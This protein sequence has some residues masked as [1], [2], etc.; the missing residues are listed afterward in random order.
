M[1]TVHGTKRPAPTA[2]QPMPI[3]QPVSLPKW[4]V[5]VI[6]GILGVIALIFGGA[7]LVLWPVQTIMVLGVLALAGG[8]AW[9]SVLRTVRRSERS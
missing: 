2:S 3:P 7:L 6:A 5:A 4:A 1:S 8:S 9:I